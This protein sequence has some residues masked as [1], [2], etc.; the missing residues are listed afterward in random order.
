[1]ALP[2]V[3]TKEVLKDIIDRI[4]HLDSDFQPKWEK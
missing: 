4:G 1:M 3:F 2:N